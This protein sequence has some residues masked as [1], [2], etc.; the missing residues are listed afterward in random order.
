MNRGLPATLLV[1]YFQRSGVDWE[2]KP[3]VRRTVEY[4]E[5]NLAEPW[6]V[7]PQFDLVFMRNVL[8]YFDLETKRSILD[9]VR[10]VL[11][12]G[13]SLF[14]GGAETTFNLNDSFER[15][16]SGKAGWYR[17]PQRS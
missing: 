6:P 9:R 15:V 13:G 2:I 7:L 10:R 17:L 8:I 11:R 5:M 4:F 14:L 16:Q 3:D 12:P 1:K